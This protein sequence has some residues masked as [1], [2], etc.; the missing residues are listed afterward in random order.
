MHINIYIYICTHFF[1]P[2]LLK[3]SITKF[4]WFC[5]AKSASAAPPWTL[6]QDPWKMLQQWGNVS[7]ERRKT[8]WKSYPWNSALDILRRCF[9]YVLEVQVPS[10]Q[11]FG[12]L[13][14]NKDLYFMIHEKHPHMYWVVFHP[15]PWTFSKPPWKN[16]TSCQSLWTTDIILPIIRLSKGIGK[17]LHLQKLFQ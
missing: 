6:L 7:H 15:L 1:P 3:F 9:R 5:C 2:H 11:V 17:K 13:G 10:Q 12:C 14:F 8:T 4:N 16:R